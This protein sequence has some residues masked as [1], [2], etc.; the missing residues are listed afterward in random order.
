MLNIILGCCVYTFVTK[1]FGRTNIPHTV[2]VFTGKFSNY[3]LPTTPGG[4]RKTSHFMGNFDLFNLYIFMHLHIQCAVTS[5]HKYRAIHINT[6]THSNCNAAFFFFSILR[7][8]RLSTSQLSCLLTT[9]YHSFFNY[10]QMT[11]F[12]VSKEKHRARL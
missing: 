12:F 8:L 7:F 2:C 10:N 5:S 4:T 11:N 1:L 6:F 3:K 9:F